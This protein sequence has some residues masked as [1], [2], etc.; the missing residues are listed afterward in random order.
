MSNAVL[1][2]GNVTPGHLVEWVT[3]GVVADAGFTFG[4]TF[5]MLAA[6][7]TQINFNNLNLDFPINI[8]LPNGFT[9]YRISGITLSNASADLSA[10]T[11]SVW[12]GAAATGTQVVTSG[13]VVTV[14]SAAADTVN[15]MQRFTVNNQN[16]V[17]YNDPILYFR[18]QNPTGTLCTGDVSIF[19]EP[20]P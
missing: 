2:S 20:L 10:A 14:T 6:T 1:Q 7:R 12:T 15:N 3:D 13:T 19:Y 8:P 9:R 16:T 17:A 18:V 4:N 11:V 5:G